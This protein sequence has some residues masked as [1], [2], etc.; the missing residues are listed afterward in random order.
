MEL[1]EGEIVAHPEPE[2]VLLVIEVTETSDYDRTVKV[3]PFDSRD[4]REHGEWRRWPPEL[5]QKVRQGNPGRY[6]DGSRPRGCTQTASR[7]TR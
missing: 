3:P 5:Q 2:D 7:M 4:H 6:S 1:I